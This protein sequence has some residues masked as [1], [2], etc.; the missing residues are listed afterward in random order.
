M[1]ISA[2][3]AMGR[4]TDQAW[5]GTVLAELETEDPEMRYEATRACGEMQLIEATSLLAQLVTDTD[6]EVKAAAVWSLGQIGTPEARR[7]LEICYEQGDEALQ[8]AADEALAE[9]DFMQ[10]AIEFPL[11][12]FQEDKDPTFWDKEDEDEDF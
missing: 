7:V 12:D 6:T 9:M 11:Y 8:D 5:A 10:G 1:R 3:F 2:V 4:T